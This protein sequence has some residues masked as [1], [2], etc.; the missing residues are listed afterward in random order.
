RNLEYH[1]IRPDERRPLL[2]VPLG[3]LYNER[4]VPLDADSVELIRR[5]Q[6]IAPRSRSWLVPGVGDVRMSYDRIR[7]CLKTYS[8]DLP[9]PGRVTSHRLRHTYATEMLSAGM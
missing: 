6:A 4:L 1:C 3:K 9:D 2:K 7:R 5:L 8:H